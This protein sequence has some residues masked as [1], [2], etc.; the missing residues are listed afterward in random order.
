VVDKKV[1][2]QKLLVG[3]CSLLA[4]AIGCGDDDP[5]PQ[6]LDATDE[7]TQSDV[8]AGDASDAPDALDGADGEV[9]TP[10]VRAYDATIRR[11]EFGVAHILADD[12]PSAAFGQGYSFAEDHIC[13]LADQ[14]VA[15]GVTSPAWIVLG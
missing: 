2:R 12:V 7:Q 9:W 4:F 13:T 5:G 6:D 10:P 1:T 15:A 8:D 14:I 3:G 11:D